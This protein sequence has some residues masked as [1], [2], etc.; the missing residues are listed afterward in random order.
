MIV[1][2]VINLRRRQ[3]EWSEAGVL[4]VLE[5]VMNEY[6]IDKDRV[7]LMGHSMGGNGTWHFGAKYPHLWAALAPIAAG[8]GATRAQLEKMKDLPV[9]LTG[10]DQD[11]V[12]SV[13]ASRRAARLMEEFGMEHVY[14]EVPNG[15]HSNVVVPAWEKMFP[16]FDEH[17][18]HR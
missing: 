5:L 8:Q 9:L 7:Y 4:N 6:R 11:Y 3:A 14:Y 18:R 12:A 2:R 13:E 1:N 17:R 10:G 15:S 16:F